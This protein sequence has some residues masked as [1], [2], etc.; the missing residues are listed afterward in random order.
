MKKIKSN[1]GFTGIDI[2]ISLGIISITLVILAA[3][4]F[5]IYISNVEIERRTQ[6]INYASQIFEKVS[7]YYYADVT[8][9]NFA[10]TTNASGK[11]VVAGIEIPKAY[12]VSVNIENYKTDQST[13]VVK[14]VKI[15]I[16]YKIGNRDNTLTLSR[17]KTKE[18]LIVPNKPELKSDMVAIKAQ[19]GSS[20]YKETTS[21][22]TRM[23]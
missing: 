22:D 18:V 4:Y 10:V 11:S 17:Y 20:T 8:T 9:E 12:S 5:N 21:L 7:E 19:Q 2:A 6:A 15:A 16:T 1:A 3:L 23:V 14:N 13:D